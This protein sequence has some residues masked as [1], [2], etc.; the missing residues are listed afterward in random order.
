MNK[1]WSMREHF[2]L[3]GKIAISKDTFEA[4]FR[5][6]NERI[7]FTFNGWDGKSYNGETRNAYVFRSNIPGYEDARFIKVGKSLH[8]IREDHMVEEKATGEYHKVASWFVDI[9][10]V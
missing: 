2:R 3:I 9:I 5:K 10:K 1:V 8:H 6:T 4:N 7:T